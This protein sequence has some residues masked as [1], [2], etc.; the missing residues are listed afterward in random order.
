MCNYE[1]IVDSI[2]KIFSNTDNDIRK[3]I[4]DKYKIIT[5]KTKLSFEDTLIYSLQYTQ[6]HKTKVDIINKYNKDKNKTKFLE[7]L[8]MKNML[9]YLFHITMMFIKNFRKL[10]KLILLAKINILLLRLME[11]ILILMLKH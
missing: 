10:L 1:I 4:N 2:N 3:F 11:H 8:F 6:N 9:K 5:R 7:I